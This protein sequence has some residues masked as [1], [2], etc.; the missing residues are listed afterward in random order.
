MVENDALS[1]QNTFRS[2]L[3]DCGT[4]QEH[5]HLVLPSPSSMQQETDEEVMDLD[6]GED[7][8]A[9]CSSERRRRRDMVVKCDIQERVLNPFT[10]FDSALGDQFVSG[11][12]LSRKKEKDLR[13]KIIS[14]SS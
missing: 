1:L 3:H 7:W 11:M 6:E 9:S 2:W 12:A 4:D 14:W 13:R 8:G 10:S 5:L